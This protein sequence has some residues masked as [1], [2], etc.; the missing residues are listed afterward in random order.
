LT[1]IGSSAFAYCAHLTSMTIP[2]GVGYLSGGLFA[3]CSKLGQV[4]VPA[5]VISIGY[6]TFQADPVLTSIY[7]RGD[8]PDGGTYPFTTVPNAVIYYN[9][10]QAGWGDN[11]Y[12]IPTVRWSPQISRADANFGMHAGRFGFNITATNN[13]TVMVEACTNISQ[14]VWSPVTTMNVNGAP[15]LF[16][17]PKTT[18]FVARFYHLEMP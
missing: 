5:S 14:P 17:D 15:A 18:N 13:L 3:D 2:D 11:Y 7:F 6:M 9:P 8:A 1:S 4:T 16:S 10:G 12:G